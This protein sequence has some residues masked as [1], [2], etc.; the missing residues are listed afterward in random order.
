MVFI[1]LEAF[2]LHGNTRLD[3]SMAGNKH[4]PTWP[5]HSIFMW[6]FVICLAVANDPITSENWGLNDAE[7]VVI[8]DQIVVHVLVVSLTNLIP[9]F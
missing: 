1:Y 9:R 2:S 4:W 8:L 7:Y 5:T 6:F 3:R